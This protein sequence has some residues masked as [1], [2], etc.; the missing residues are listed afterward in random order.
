MRNERIA[1][2]GFL[3]VSAAALAFAAGDLVAQDARD[4]EALAARCAASDPGAATV[5]REGAVALQAAQAGMGLLAAGGTQ[6][7]GAS[8]TLGRR[9]GGMP[10]L[11]GSV[12]GGL[13]LLEIPDVRAAST[14]SGRSYTGLATQASLALGVLDGFSPIPTVGGVL[15]L[16]LFATLGTLVLPEGPGFL[17]GSSQ[18]GLGANIGLLRESFTTPGISV[19]IAR[20]NMSETRLGARVSGDA[21]EITVDPSVT[22]LRAVVGKDLLALGVVAGVGW[23]SY[24]SDGLLVVTG[25]G[26]APRPTEVDGFSAD[27][28][29]A[30]GGVSLSFLVL[31]LSAEG[32]LA[33]GFGAVS[34]RPSGGYDPEGASFF[35]SIAGRLTL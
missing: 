27:R 8:S 26:G 5:C 2:V 29:L 31:Q 12:R 16:D 13:A 6:V 20:R 22:S 14:A 10:R 17:E 35:L 1:L 21:V 4:V 11:S 34:G 7:P 28:T 32:G 25:S 9:F 24:K 30:F 33:R 15:S 18:W 23:D 3:I 19:A